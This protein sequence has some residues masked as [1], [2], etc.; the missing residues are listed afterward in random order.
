M[1]GPCPTC[2]GDGALPILD[3]IDRDILVV[4]GVTCPTCH[5]I[6]P[7]TID[8]FQKQCTRTE[9]DYA[10]AAARLQDLR[11][12][13]LL[14]A[15][16]GLCTEAAEFLDILKK[17]IFYGKPLDKAHLKEE[18][19]DGNWYE[20]IACEVL[21]TQ[22]LSILQQNIKKLRTR[23]PDKFTEEL[24]LVRDLDAE[25]AVLEGK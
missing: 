1:S 5:G 21:E 15:A 23:Y 12:V 13:R 7:T 25:R 18:L 22:F 20:G 19:G 10:V 3:R 9:G 11:T 24:A 6:M 16:M 14:H 17:H 2:N 8:T 4:K